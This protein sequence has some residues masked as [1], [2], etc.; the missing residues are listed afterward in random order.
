MISLNWFEDFSKKTDLT[1]KLAKEARPNSSMIAK[2]AIVQ[3]PFD[4]INRIYM[5]FFF[6]LLISYFKS[7]IIPISNQC[8]HSIS[9]LWD[10]HR[11]ST[12]RGCY[13]NTSKADSIELNH[14]KADRPGLWLRFSP[15][16]RLYEPEGRA[17]HT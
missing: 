7:S 5:I 2:N 16:R 12:Q 14:C 13:Y 3:L 4:R 9:L 10:L 8:P 6:I 11:N 15:G 17:L 1:L